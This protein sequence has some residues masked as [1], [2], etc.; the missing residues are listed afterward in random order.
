M[1]LIGVG[2]QKVGLGKKTK[3]RVQFCSGEGFMIPAGSGLPDGFWAAGSL[4]SD[5][6]QGSS[7]SGDWVGSASEEHVGRWK[8]YLDS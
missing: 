7:E 6:E 3:G 1:V 5:T 4:R 2:I 8:C